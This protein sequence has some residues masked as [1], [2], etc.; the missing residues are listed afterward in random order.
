VRRWM[1]AL[2]FASGFAA[3]I[4]QVTWVRVLTVDFGTTVYAVST[5]LTVFM[6]G[7]ALGSWAFGRWID[8]G[9]HPLRAYGGI[10]IA[11]G[12]YAAL[13]A[14]ATPYLHTLTTW[15]IR[16]GSAGHEATSLVKFAIAAVLLLPP[17]VLMGGTLPVLA[18]F[19]TDS[20]KTAGSRLGSLYAF[21]TLGAVLGS[22]AA[23][24]ALI[25]VLGVRGSMLFAAAI[26]GT[27]GVVSFGLSRVASPPKPSEAAPADAAAAPAEPR[28]E[29][30]APPLAVVL[31]VAFF[32]G[33]ITLA[34]EVLW[35]RLFINFLTANVLVFATILAAFLAGIAFGS[36]VVA[37]WVDRARRLDR[38]LTVLLA[39]SALWLVASVVGQPA[40]GS[41][42]DAIR[43]LDARYSQQVAV[44]ASLAAM[45]VAVVLPAATFG[46]VFPM[47]F[48]W[49]S[50]S[51]TTI[52][53]DVGRLYATN[54]AGSILGSFM[55]GFVMIR[56]LGLNTSLL[57]LAA[58]YA[59]L[60]FFMTRRRV[61]RAG[62]LAIAAGCVALA[63]MPRFREPIYWF[64]SGF[65][66]VKQVPKEGILFLAEGVE[67]TVGVMQN[68]HGRMLTVNGVIVAEST[69]QDLWDLLLK[70]HLPMLIHP[71]PRRVALVGLGAGVSLGAV[72]AYDVERIDCVEI[73]EEVVPAHKFFE[74]V[75]GRCWED[76]RLHLWIND[77]RH[78]L[79]TTDQRYDVISVDPTDPPVVYQYSQDFLQVCHDRLDDGGIM[80]HWVPLFHLS[81]LH[82]RIIMQA[83]ANVF[84]HTSLWYDGTSVLLVGSKGRPLTIDIARFEE[85]LAR[86]DVQ[87][88]L[89]PIG[90]PDASLLLATFC[91]AR[92][93]VDRVIGDGVP[94][95]TDDRPYLEYKV[96]LAGRLG[97]EAMAS[98]LEMLAPHYEFSDA[99][100]DPTLSAEVAATLRTNQGLM[101]DLLGIRTAVMRGERRKVRTLRRELFDTYSL[102]TERRRLLNPFVSPA[103]LTN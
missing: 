36:F 1:N 11:L 5:V 76:P 34:C 27:L 96:L 29:A 7:L 91:F 2:F 37:S 93:G 19:L 58:C 70:A 17:T 48:R 30:H 78:F 85:R 49:C 3:L 99:L 45:F 71:D 23:A 4:Y 26:N 84:P 50:R 77:G 66:M 14:L 31:S 47:L 52:G 35:T 100:F 40:L 60:A 80:V 53:A 9:A 95:N 82:V 54:T 46:A 42:F 68:R 28:D 16:G 86:P 6:A 103:K 88:N 38:A 75:N 22:L 59:I 94:A 67:G 39:T 25:P 51:S 8:R 89:A 98:N 41:A 72:E 57:A 55:S 97:H 64:N 73:S 13:F 24:Y 15:A 92:D 18:K 43:G 21:N 33:F 32:S 90:A 101:K 63:A 10:E 62:V 81:P 102:D 56:A 20:P 83:F 65:H 12:V 79:H 74:N 61:L 44:F 69:T 87:R